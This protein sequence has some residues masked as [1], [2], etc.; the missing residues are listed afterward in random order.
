MVT[1]LWAPAF[2]S[3]SYFGKT[4]KLTTFSLSLWGST[5]LELMEGRKLRQVITNK[6]SIRT[7]KAQEGGERVLI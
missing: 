6:A 7:D 3:S 1:F 5:Q 2:V 4:T